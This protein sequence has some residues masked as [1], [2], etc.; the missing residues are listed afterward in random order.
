MVLF[1]LYY[2]IIFRRVEQFLTTVIASCRQILC[3]FQEFLTLLVNVALCCSLF[4]CHMSLVTNHTNIWMKNPSLKCFPPSMEEM[5]LFRI[6]PENC[7]ALSSREV[8]P[9]SN[10][11]TLI[12]PF[13][14]LS[15]FSVY[16]PCFCEA[17]LS[18]FL[19][20]ILLCHICL[21]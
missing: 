12:F 7:F 15:H 9:Y 4:F 11:I 3:W 2:W 5:P 1:D 6:Q 17:Q 18:L 10:I 19:F 20:K 16:F 13:I 8:S 14:P 21:P